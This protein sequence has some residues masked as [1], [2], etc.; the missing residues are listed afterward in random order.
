MDTTKEI[1]KYVKRKYGFVPKSCWIA[2]AKE[3]SGIPVRRAWNRK[4]DKRVY[5]CPEDK[6]K[7][8]IEAIKYIRLDKT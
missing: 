8:I 2:H 3:M 4:S 1:Q 7:A 5:P 6:R